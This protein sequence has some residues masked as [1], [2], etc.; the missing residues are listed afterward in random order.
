MKVA[1]TTSTLQ[2][3]GLVLSDRGNYSCFSSN[4]LTSVRT[5][6]SERLEF[7]VLC[8]STTELLNIDLYSI[9]YNKTLVSIY[10]SVSNI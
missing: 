2:I 9:Y 5:L 1:N 7:I 6:E 8:K 4:N 10:L 3:S